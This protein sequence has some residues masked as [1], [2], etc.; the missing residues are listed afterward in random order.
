[1]FQR[2][3]MSKSFFFKNVI[4]CKSITWDYKVGSTDIVKRFIENISLKLIES[5]AKTFKN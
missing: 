4:E 3:C 5:R 1:M 2:Y